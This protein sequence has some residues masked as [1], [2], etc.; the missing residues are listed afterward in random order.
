MAYGAAFLLLSVGILMRVLGHQAI[1][2]RSLVKK[3]SVFKLGC[4]NDDGILKQSNGILALT[5]K[6]VWIWVMQF[7]QF[8]GIISVRRKIVD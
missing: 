2:E 7:M 6:Q 4:G 3:G 8:V 5:N 1:Q